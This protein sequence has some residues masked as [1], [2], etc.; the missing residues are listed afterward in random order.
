MK[1]TEGNINKVVG[2]VF[3]FMKI[4]YYFEE[5]DTLMYKWQTFHFINEL[6]EY[7]IDVEIFNPSFFNSIKEANKSL[8]ERCKKQDYV[9]FMTPHNHEK[10]FINTLRVI[11]DLKIPTLLI[12]FDNLVIPFEHRKICSVFDLVW[13]TSKETEGMFKQWGA[14]TVFLPYASNPSLFKPSSKNEVK[15]ICFVG[16]PYGSRTNTL[17][18]LAGNGIN[19]DLYSNVKI[20]VGAKT[21]IGTERYIKYCKSIYN[22]IRFQH[23]RTILLG[24]LKNKFVGKNSLVENKI[25]FFA[26]VP[27]ECLGEIYSMYAL[28]LAST[29]ARNTGV[30]TNPL[31]I[32]NL[33]SFEI[34]MAG[35]LQICPYSPEL[36]RY[37]KENEEIIFYRSKSEMIEKVNFY[38]LDENTE[39]RANIKKAARQRAIEDHTWYKRFSVIFQLLGISHVNN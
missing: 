19:L 20:S 14:K 37:F 12:C 38:L 9:L 7:D 31:H 28:S 36:A 8:I 27:L 32:V 13:L 6:K 33:R 17:N 25:N 3:L 11:K 24:A 34:S 39:L 26:P 2:F 16:T 30:L 23:G 5:K 35:G 21:K 1:L 10:L 15:K 29:S 18:D 4:L 22:L